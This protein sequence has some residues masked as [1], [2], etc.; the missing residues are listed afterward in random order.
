MTDLAT[1]SF[2]LS[3]LVSISARTLSPQKRRTT[4]RQFQKSLKWN[5][6]NA[7]GLLQ[8]W[9]K[10]DF[11]ELLF[12]FPSLQKLLESNTTFLGITRRN[13]S[14][15]PPTARSSQNRSR[16]DSV[17]FCENVALLVL[18]QEN[19]PVLRCRVCMGSKWKKK[20]P[21]LTLSAFLELS[22]QSSRQIEPRIQQKA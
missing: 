8:S 13:K 15:L 4:A 2:P 9:Q 21:S 18:E 22:I 14:E 16:G 6:W 5:S 17:N 10:Y 12:A 7:I 20:K 11:R 3:F 1:N 19:T